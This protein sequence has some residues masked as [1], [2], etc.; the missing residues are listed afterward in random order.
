MLRTRIL[1]LELKLLQ[2]ANDIVGVRL[3]SWIE[4]ILKKGK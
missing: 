3:T 1:E 2:A 4:R